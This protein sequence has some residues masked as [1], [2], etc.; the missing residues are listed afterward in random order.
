MADTPVVERFDIK[1]WFSGFVNPTTWSKALVYLIIG[2]IIVFILVCVKNFFF[3]SKAIT[4]KPVGIGLN[5][6]GK[7]EKDAINQTSTN[8][9]VDKEKSF[10]VGVGVGAGRFD[11]KDGYAGGVWGKWKF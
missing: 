8:I 3:P 1:K 7:V 9:V 5:I 4:N 2:G 11:N 10:E 6:G